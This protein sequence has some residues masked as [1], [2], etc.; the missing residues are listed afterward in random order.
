VTAQL[1]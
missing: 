1:Q